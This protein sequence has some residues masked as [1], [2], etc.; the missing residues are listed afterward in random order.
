MN[1]Y[2]MDNRNRE[3]K[4]DPPLAAR[5]YWDELPEGSLKTLRAANTD[6]HRDDLKYVV[7]ASSKPCEGWSAVGDG[8]TT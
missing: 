5:N 4:K 2:H 8:T 7:K 6:Y 3:G 1:V